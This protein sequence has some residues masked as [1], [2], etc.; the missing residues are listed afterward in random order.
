MS[1]LKSLRGYMNGEINESALQSA[2]YS[3]D[4]DTTEYE[5]DTAYMQE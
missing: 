3:T 2:Q 1:L 5:N 4:D